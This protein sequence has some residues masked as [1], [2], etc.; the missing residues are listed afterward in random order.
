[1]ITYLVHGDHRYTLADYFQERGRALRE[2]VV[3]RSYEEVID[4]GELPR[5]STVF[6]AVDQ[7]TPTERRLATRMWDALSAAFPDACLLNHPERVLLR[8]DLL[9]AAQT[10]GT[11][12]F[13]VCRATR[14]PHD[15]RYPVFVRLEHEH[16]GSLTQPI[17][18]HRA[19]RR[20]LLELVVRGYRWRD[21]LVVEYCDTADADGQMHKYSAYNVAG[22]IIPCFLLV[23]TDWVT[24][25]PVRRIDQDTAREE[26]AFVCGNPHGEW[27]RAMFALGRIDYGRIDYNVRD[28]QPQMWEI[29]TNPMIGR[30]LRGPNR[31]TDAQRQLRAPS[32]THVAARFQ[33]AWEAIDRVP[34]SDEPVPF[35]VSDDERRRVGAERRAARRIIARRDLMTRLADAPGISAMRRMWRAVSPDAMRRG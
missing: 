15:L 17:P 28:G 30:R 23:S 31:W 8:Y 7:L 2:R 4:A 14:V 6:A 33:L 3:I 29:N 11:N 5:A 21:L 19:L 10:H 22:D 27:V 18:N 20:M 25:A 16:T 24:K 12:V 13:R 34:P 35:P 9:R 26:L 1:M 32:R